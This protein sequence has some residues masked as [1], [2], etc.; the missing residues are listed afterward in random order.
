MIS[1]CIRR[2]EKSI[3]MLPACSQIPGIGKILITGSLVAAFLKLMHLS[4]T[5]V[6]N[7]SLS[8]PK[9][10]VKVFALR[11]LLSFYLSESKH[12]LVAD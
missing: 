6:V 5:K 11:N 7:I 9:K 1:I 12:R 8:S 10:G 2:N 4:Q 3:K